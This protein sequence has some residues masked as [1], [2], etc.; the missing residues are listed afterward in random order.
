MSGERRARLRALAK[1]NLDLRVLSG[2]RDGYHEIRTV[3]QTISLADRLEIAFTPGSRTRIDLEDG[4]GIQNNLVV[5]AAEL[6]LRALK[7]RGRVSFRLDKRIPL[8][9]GLGGGSSDAAAVLLAL[10]VL[11]SR[12]VEMAQL[13]RL[14]AQL[15]SDVPFFLM[16]GTAVGLGRGEEIYPLP[17]A[18]PLHGVLIAPGIHSSTP[19]AYRALDGRRLTTE[20]E[21]NT[22]FSFQS[23]VWDSFGGL[24]AERFPR[25]GINDFEENLFR[26]FPRLRR[27]KG[28]LGRLG[29]ESV[30][31]TGSGSAVFGIF[32]AHERARRAISSLRKDIKVL[33]WQ[34][35]SL[36]AAGIH[37][38][39]FVS[40]SR[41]RALWWSGLRAHLSE[42][43]WPPQSR[44]AQ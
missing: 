31:M 10:P 8:G 41:Y 17:D 16:G 38:I 12:R 7:V 29:A 35:P 1:I 13:L 14:A 11:A 40:R 22:I 42:K 44:Y 26:R 43:V 32:G 24:A 39:A 9:A 2:R 33:S 6:C 27:I 25:C 21:Q 5:R 15:G 18:W 36:E 34:S 23:W 19:E 4:S 3:Y 30:L 20:S 37:P 28:S